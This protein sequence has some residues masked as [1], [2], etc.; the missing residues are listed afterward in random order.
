MIDFQTHR[1]DVCGEQFN[2]ACLSQ[3]QEK[4]KT[5]RC[6]KKNKRVEQLGS[7][8][9]TELLSMYVTW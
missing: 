5:H 6:I 1:C 7:L 2:V 8:D 3:L 4:L 9:V